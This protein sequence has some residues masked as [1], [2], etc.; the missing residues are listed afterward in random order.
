MT[1]ERKAIASAPDDS[2]LRY[3]SG[4]GNEFASEAVQGVLPR[5]QNSPQQVAHGLYAEQLNGTPF[6]APRGLNRRSWLYRIRPSVA[7]KPF[8]SSAREG[9]A[10]RPSMRRRRRPTNCAG[11]RSRLPSAPTDFIDG[12]VTMAGNGNAA[13]HSGVAVHIYIANASMTDRFFYNADGE[14]LIVPQQGRLLLR[15]EMGIIAA[16]PGE[17]AVVQRGIRFR[18]ELLDGQARGYA[19]ENYGALLRLPDLGPIGA[20]GLANPRDFL[21]PWQR[22][23]S[24]KAISGSSPNSRAG[25]GRQPSITRPST[26]LPGTATMLLTNTTWPASIASTR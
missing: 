10:V 19:C 7:H 2:G 3:Q 8:A 26:W 12:L 14:M 13:M 4:F 16:G 11:S 15:T 20:N 1:D 22:L 17:I 25:Y 5:G 24:A 18:V 6:T 23:R 21:R 9:C